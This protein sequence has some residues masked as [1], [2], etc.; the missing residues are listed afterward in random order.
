MNAHWDV[1]L[2]SLIDVSEEAAVSIL[3]VNIL[4]LVNFTSST[5][6]CAFVQICMVEMAVYGML[7][8]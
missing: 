7:K 6:L 2:C 3:R 4:P 5:I 8:E 1:L